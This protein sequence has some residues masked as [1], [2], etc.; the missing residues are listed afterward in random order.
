ME[1][2]RI[3]GAR[4]RVLIN[5]SHAY[6]S[7]FARLGAFELSFLL[8]LTTGTKS[9]NR[10]SLKYV[11]RRQVS[12]L[13][14]GAPLI[15]CLIGNRDSFHIRK[16][17]WS[18]RINSSSVSESF[19]DNTEVRMQYYQLKQFL[20]WL[21]LLFTQLILKERLFVYL[22]HLAQSR[23][24]FVQAFLLMHSNDTSFDI[25]IIDYSAQGLS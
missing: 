21:C 9:Y 19:V 18:S 20:M 10:N 12:N 3:G 2:R 13:P 11:H 25:P 22:K 15:L 24:V 17:C 6:L 23:S 16:F 7:L 14:P 4:A 5:V 8:S 1:G